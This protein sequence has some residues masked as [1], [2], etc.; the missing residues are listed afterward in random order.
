M[1]WLGL[2]L[3]ALV[4]AG[5]VLTGLPAFT[6][7]L[8]AA[9]VGAA[10]AVF[11]GTIPVSLLGALPGR[12]INLLEYDLLQA[13]PLY[14]FMGVLLERLPIADALFRTSLRILPRSAAAPVISGLSLG[15]LLGPMNGSVG[16]SV[17]SLSRSV[18]PRLLASGVSLP[19][20]YA[21]IAVASTLGVVIPPSLVLILL[22]DA[23]LSAHT[24]AVTA[25]GRADRVINT[26][27][28]FH[29]AL[30]P[31]GL[32]FAGSLVIAWLTTRRLPPT[33][34]VRDAISVR[35]ALLAAVSVLA[36]LL[37]LGGVATGY[38]YAV[39]GAATGAF[40]LLAAGLFTGSLPAP[41]LAAALADVM[42]ITGALFALLV[43]ATTL[44]LVLRLLGTD[45]LVGDWV[46]GLPGNEVTVVV[47][48][49][50]IIGLSAFVLDAFEIIFVVVPIVVPPLLIRVADARWVAVLVLLTLQSSFL[51][52]PF[53]YALMMVRGTLKE[54]VPLGALVRALA[55]F[56]LAQW[57][58]LALV[59]AVPQLVHLG[60][61]PEDR[62]R[63]PPTTLS[64][65]DVDKRLREMIPPP[66][67]SDPDLRP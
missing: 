19:L 35:Q 15:A 34:G 37:L 61:K 47:I 65:Q 8:T 13:L 9:S 49:L 67:D 54:S 60:E 66:T 3:L 24:M 44:T 4:A 23:M 11:S 56:L 16:A 22:G 64:P 42:A 6:I 14:V 30:A 52:P 48:V 46:I 12:L 17:L 36:L 27:D 62:T 10:L 43:G 59:L 40:V 18:N 45:H 41:V 7:L 20:R 55:P 33:T 26:Q 32:V 1:A 50:G 28:V 2:G 21:T 57:A 5:I 25:T 38:F 58:V 51:L 53:G 63:A 39:E 31:A 29:G